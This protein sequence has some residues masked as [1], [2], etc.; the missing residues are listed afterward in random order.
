[1]NA[2]FRT[3]LARLNQV[4]DWQVDWSGPSPEMNPEYRCLSGRHLDF[5]VRIEW[6]TA[7]EHEHGFRREYWKG[8]EPSGRWEDS[9]RF[10]PIRI[11]RLLLRAMFFLF[12]PA[13]REYK[14]CDLRVGTSTEDTNHWVDLYWCIFREGSNEYRSI[15]EMVRRLVG[16]EQD[17]RRA[18]LQSFE[19]EMEQ[20]GNERSSAVAAEAQKA[21]QRFWRR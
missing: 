16:K 6:H 2:N 9:V 1:M 3:V 12:E 15:E 20:D 13:D 19:R 8:S 11:V 18:A 10:G 7:Y 5:T 21:R 4:V 17:R 14:W